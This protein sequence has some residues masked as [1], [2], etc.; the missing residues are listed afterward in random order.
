[1]YLGINFISCTHSSG[2]IASYFTAFEKQNTAFSTLNW[3]S[4][5]SF[6]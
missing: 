5:S 3:C 1:M 4:H 6:L 2:I